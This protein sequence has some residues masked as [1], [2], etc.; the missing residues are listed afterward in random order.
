MQ[1]SAVVLWLNVLSSCTTVLYRCVTFDAHRQSFH[2]DT[3]DTG[4]AAPSSIGRLAE[5]L[6][7]V[8]VNV[9]YRTDGSSLAAIAA[10]YLLD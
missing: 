4:P 8:N 1:R 7:N 9:K 10:R 5:W 2:F 6:M 3:E